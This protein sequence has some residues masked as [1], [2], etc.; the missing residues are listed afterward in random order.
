MFVS[1]ILNLLGYDISKL[2]L[3]KQPEIGNTEVVSKKQKTSNDGSQE[4]WE[5][6]L[7]SGHHV[8]F[9]SS[10][11]SMLNLKKPNNLSDFKPPNN[12][13]EM[14]AAAVH[15][16]TGLT[17]F[18][19]AS[20]EM[21]TTSQEYSVHNTQHVQFNYGSLLFPYILQI[22][23]SLHLVYEELKMNVLLIEDLQS[24]A[25]FLYQLCIDLGLDAY[26]N[27]YW[28]DCPNICKLNYDP[29]Q[30][31]I[32]EIDLKRII[33]PTYFNPEPPNIFNHLYMLLKRRNDIKYPYINNVNTISKDI[34]EVSLNTYFL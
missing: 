22:S 20:S 7:N 30:R 11:A 2:A 10:L 24:L 23:F 8:S 13:F 16:L 18:A 12:A 32:S 25:Q 5:Y 17:K 21:D 6:L 3:T 15:K 1:L 14:N 33:Q 31:Q 4:D 28:K 9:G 29:S 27:H 19:H 26:I 34:V